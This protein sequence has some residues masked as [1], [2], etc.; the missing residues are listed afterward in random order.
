MKGLRIHSCVIQNLLRTAMLEY[1]VEDMKDLKFKVHVKEE[2]VEDTSSGLTAPKSSIHGHNTV[3]AHACDIQAHG[4][5]MSHGETTNVHG[6]EKASRST[7]DIR[8][9][10]SDVEQGDDATSRCTLTRLHRPMM[11]LLSPHPRRRERKE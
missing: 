6:D 11:C 5:Q 8:S 7:S 10:H 9:R 1:A 4:I 2:K 3:F